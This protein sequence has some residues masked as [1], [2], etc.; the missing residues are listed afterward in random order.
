MGFLNEATDRIELAQFEELNHLW[1][2]PLQDL[3]V[4]RHVERKRA[5]MKGSVDEK[6]EE[7][8]GGN[9]TY[10]WFMNIL[11]SS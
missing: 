2:E 7:S 4:D 11:R 3:F 8:L 1:I 5:R 10:E 9:V 6:F